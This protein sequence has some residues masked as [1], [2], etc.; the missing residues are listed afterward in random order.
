AG[1]VRVDEISFSSDFKHVQLLLL[2]NLE[3]KQIFDKAEGFPYQYFY[4]P[5]EWVK[6]ISLEGNY[7]EERDLLDL[8]NM[9][10]T[11]LECHQFIVKNKEAY[12]T[13]VELAADISIKPSHAQRIHSV[14]DENAII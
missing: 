12:P 7:L 6:I 2:Q 10:L 3:F 8:G 9:L 4:D 11:I 14:I 1:K 5:S 13:L